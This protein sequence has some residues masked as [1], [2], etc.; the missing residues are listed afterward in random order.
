MPLPQHAGVLSRYSRTKVI[1]YTVVAGIAVAAI[2]WAFLALADP[3]T[4]IDWQLPDVPGSEIVADT[5]VQSNVTD[6]WARYL[7]VL[8]D[9]P[10]T[11]K[12]LTREM[13]AALDKAGWET[14]LV[15]EGSG[16]PAGEVE[17]DSGSKHVSFGPANSQRR[18]VP[19]SVWELIKT[20]EGPVGRKV[21]VGMSE[22]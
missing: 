20:T 5:E 1:A 22:Y 13:R 9:P 7:I 19:E 4:R 15:R 6:S 18:F 16:F 17:A 3:G 10:T 14:R 11:A 2:V 8:A 12:D 21:A